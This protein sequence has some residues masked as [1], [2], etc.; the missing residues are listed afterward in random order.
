M[1]TEHN[2]DVPDLVY[3]VV[4][5]IFS[6]FSA[7]AVVHFLKLKNSEGKFKDNLRYESYYSILSFTSKI[8]LLA[9]L[10][11]GVISRGDGRV[12]FPDEIRNSTMYKS[13]VFFVSHRNLLFKKN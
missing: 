10:F 8:L 2:R 5:V 13:C 9:T 4:F 7:F 12:R 3:V 11:T 6:L 1:R